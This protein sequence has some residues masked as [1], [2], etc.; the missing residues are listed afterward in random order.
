MKQREPPIA[1]PVS[2][3]ATRVIASRSCTE[4]TRREILATRRSRT[5]AW[6]RAA[7]DRVRSSAIAASPA[8]ASIRRNSSVPNA[9]RSVVVAA[10]ITPITCSSTISGT[11]AALFAPAA[12]REAGVD[13]RR[14]VA[15]VDGHGGG[16]EERARDAG[17]LVVQVQAHLAPPRQVLPAGAGEQADRL[18]LVA[19]DERQRVELGLDQARDLVEQGARR[20]DRLLDPGQRVDDAPDRLELAVADADELLCFTRASA[21][22]HDSCGLAPAPEEDQRR[23]ERDERGHERRPDVAA[24]RGAVVQHLRREDPGR[25]PDR[26]KDR[27]QP[28]VGHAHSSPLSPERGRERCGH[29]QVGTRQDEQ[30]DSV[31]VDSLVFGTHWAL[32]MIRRPPGGVE[33]STRFPNRKA[34]HCDLERWAGR[35]IG[36]RRDPE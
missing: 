13:E 18:V 24:D 33:S 1:R 32:G 14:G 7:A 15:V 19:V 21:A 20:V 26:G 25:D 10:T 2:V 35:P 11:N 8:S 5:R 12:L 22:H 31:E 27:R 17:G 29:H 16:L 9:R 28:D 36:I 30:R 23:D 34:P 3:T 6:S 4:R